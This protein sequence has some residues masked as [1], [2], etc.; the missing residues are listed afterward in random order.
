MLHLGLCRR[1]VAYVALVHARR[2][3]SSSPPFH[4][5]MPTTTRSRPTQGESLQLSVNLVG[6]ENYTKVPFSVQVEAIGDAAGD[7]T[8]Q[9]SET[10]PCFS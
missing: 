6:A 7:I 8:L 3:F 5:L 2:G 10:A 1:S 9:P 4:D